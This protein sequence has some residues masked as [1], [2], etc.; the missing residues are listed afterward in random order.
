M[1]NLVLESSTDRGFTGEG[2]EDENSLQE[3]ENAERQ[4]GL[5]VSIDPIVLI[6]HIGRNHVNYPG[7]ACNMGLYEEEKIQILILFLPMI[8]NN[9]A[10]VKT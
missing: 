10:R 4:S 6:F 9:L 1:L 8:T 5:V 2:D 3:V 7:Y